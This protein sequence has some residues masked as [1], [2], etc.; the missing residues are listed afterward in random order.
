MEAWKTDDGI[1]EISITNEIDR[2]NFITKNKYAEIKDINDFKE[3]SR[4]IRKQER[5]SIERNLTEDLH[6]LC[7][8]CRYGHI[9]QTRNW[10]PE[11]WKV[12][13]FKRINNNIERIWKI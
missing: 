4:Y 12:E 5:L 10:K 11:R 6:I 8:K 13:K 7:K 3:E 1:E 9:S 2:Q